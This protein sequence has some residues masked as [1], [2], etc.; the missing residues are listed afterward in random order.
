MSAFNEMTPI[1]CSIN[2]KNLRN[3]RK[4]FISLANNSYW[5]IVVKF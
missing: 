2:G 4:I 3:R 1:T 5:N